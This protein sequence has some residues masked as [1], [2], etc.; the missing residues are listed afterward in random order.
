MIPLTLNILQQEVQLVQETELDRDDA[1]ILSSILAHSTNQ[2]A[3]RKA[4]LTG[5]INDFQRP[6]VREILAEAKIKLFSS[7]TKVLGW[8]SAEQD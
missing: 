5:N 7:T 2:P 4:F 6:T 3:A 1:L 8:A